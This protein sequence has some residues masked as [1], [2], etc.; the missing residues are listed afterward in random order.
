MPAHK[1][2][3]KTFLFAYNL[4]GSIRKNQV[5]TYLLFVGLLYWFV[6]GR[7]RALSVRG[8]ITVVTRP[9]GAGI[10]ADKIT[11]FEEYSLE[12]CSCAVV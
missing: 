2:A 7:L 10:T 11:N 3:T 8:C 9:L 5:I 1:S 4:Y 12:L 6:T